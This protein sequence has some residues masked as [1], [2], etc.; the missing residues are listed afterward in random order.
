M[1]RQLY[2]I[3]GGPGA[4]LAMRRHFKAALAAAKKDKPVVAYVGAASGDNAGFQKMITA[5]LMGSG[6]RFRAAKL[7]K[8][9]AKT[10]EAKAVLEGAD[11]IFMS[12]GDVEAG[13]N[14]LKERDL[15]PFFHKLADEKPFVAVSAGSLMLA[16]EWVRF[17]NEHDDASAETFDCLGIADL[18]VDA[19]S[20]DD[21]WS[22]LRTLVKLLHARGDKEP[23]GY[24]L[25]RKGCLHIRG[26]NG[27][28]NLTALGT[29]IPR[30]VVR[31]G[32]VAAGKPLAPRASR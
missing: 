23:V 16:K 5:G 14:V 20:E 10:S 1:K 11:V 24:G 18:H 25:T 30:I 4:L 7:A 8:K 19:H 31:S 26:E 6:A 17:P 3:G 9:T 2:L 15:I 22:E 29:E 28:I 27:A 13:M 32:K 12:G 21:D